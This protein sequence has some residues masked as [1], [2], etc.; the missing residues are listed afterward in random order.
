[1]RPA[2]VVRRATDYLERHGV[3]SPR[4]TAEQLM[5]HVLG[6]DR[7][8]LFSRTQGLDAREARMYGRAICQRCS[9][10]PLQHLTGRQAFRRIEV[11]VRPGVFVPRPETEV[12]VEHALAAIQVSDG[13]LVADVGTGTGA[14]GLAIKDERPDA[15]VFATDR[16]AEA[17]DLA[18]AN[19]RR[20]RID[21]TVLEGDLLTPLPEELR[22]WFDLVVS[23]PPYVTP[24]EYEGLPPEVKA[25]PTLALLGGPEVYER[26]AAEALRWLRD[27]GELPVLVPS[28]TS[29]K[30]IAS[31]DEPA[32]RL[33]TRFWAGAL[34]LVLRRTELS[35]GWHL[36]G[37]AE[38]IGVR[39]PHHPLALAVLTLTGP[40]AVTSANRSGESTPATCDGVRAVFGDR[41]AAYLCESSPVEGRASTVV[42]LTGGE[43]RF[44]RV[45]ALAESAVVDALSEA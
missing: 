6:T 23:N 10:T 28:L 3:E 41:V 29:A 13:P 35:R 24:E 1:M 11:E 2:E 42:D 18:L 15:R 44:L 40:L 26:L 43:L 33:A 25:D 19:A 31:F 9:G 37:N 45:G 21:V 7:A 38:T 5:I 16:S 30:Q 14:I 8:G 17:V 34:T 32:L 22:G 27:G 39:M 4:A 36:G 20:L 12:L